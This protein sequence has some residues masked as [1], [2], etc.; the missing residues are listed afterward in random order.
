MQVVI[1]IINRPPFTS[2]HIADFEK[3]VVLGNAGVM[4]S[5]VVRSWGPDD[6]GHTVDGPHPLG[7][8]RGGIFHTTVFVQQRAA[9][10]QNVSTLLIL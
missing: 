10:M 1:T 9:Q 3:G 6:D 5:V 7:K 8:V 2:T 4:I